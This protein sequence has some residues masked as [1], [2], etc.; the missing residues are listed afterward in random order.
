M[1]EARDK[2]LEQMTQT[3]KRKLTSEA[4]EE[5]EEEGQENVQ[6]I[7]ILLKCD[8]WGSA[9]AVEQ[10]ISEIFE[11]FALLHHKYMYTYMYIYIYMCVCV[12]TC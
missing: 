2:L 5:E 8:I 3:A 10:A 11:V 9:T 4:V 6:E 7:V 1:D 12:C